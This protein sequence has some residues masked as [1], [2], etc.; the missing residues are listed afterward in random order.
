MLK[1]K[2]FH[3]ALSA[4]LGLLVTLHIFSNTYGRNGSFESLGH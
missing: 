2:I 1:F 3:E 4:N